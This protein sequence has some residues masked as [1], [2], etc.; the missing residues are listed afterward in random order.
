MATRST[1]TVNTLGEK[2]S[3]APATA[4]SSMVQEKDLARPMRS[5]MLPYGGYKVHIRK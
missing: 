5:L 4:D 3:S 2:T 1:A